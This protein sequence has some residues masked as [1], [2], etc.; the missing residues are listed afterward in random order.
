VEEDTSL[1]AGCNSD[2]S[3]QMPIKWKIKGEIDP[4]RMKKKTKFS[5]Q[6]YKYL[7]RINIK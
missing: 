1:T 7:N 2:L 6:L 3:Q 5:L 4:L